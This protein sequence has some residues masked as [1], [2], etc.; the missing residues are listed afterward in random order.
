MK[1]LRFYLPLAIISGLL[2]FIA[3]KSIQGGDTSELVMAGFHRLVAH[4]PGYPLFV[5]LQFTWTHLFE[6]STVFWRAS[7]LSSLFGAIALAAVGL[8]LKNSKNL[9]W[10]LLLLVVGLKSEVLESSVLPDVF[11]LH[12]L[13][14]ALIGYFFLFSPHPKKHSWVIFL[15]ILSLTNHHTAVFLFPVFLYSFWNLLVRKEHRSLWLA[16]VSGLLLFAGLYFSILLLNPKHSLSWGE[17]YNLSGLVHHFLRTDYGTF[18]LAATQ[19]S[20][21]TEAFIFMLKNLWP[22][23]LILTVVAGLSI[24]TK[25]IILKNGPFI[26]WSLAL[27]IT[28]AFPLIMN[29]TS[30]HVGAEVLRRFHVMPIM[31]L[32]SW[33][34]FL[35]RNLDLTKKNRIIL[36]ASIMP[37]LYSNF[38]SAPEFFDLRNDSVI[39]DYAKN[40]YSIGKSQ[41]NSIIVA[42][43]DTS[44]FALRYLQS[45]DQDA[46]NAKV[47]I[48][49]LPLFFHQ[50]YLKKVQDQ[51][52]GFNL[53]RSEEIYLKKHINKDQDIFKPNLF[54]MRFFLTKGYTEG[55]MYKVTFFPLGRMLEEGK[56]VFFQ[57]FP[58]VIKTIPEISYRGPQAFTKLKLFFEYSHYDYARAVELTEANDFNGAQKSMEDAISKVPYAYPAMASLCMNF[59]DKYDF[60]KSTLLQKLEEQTLYFY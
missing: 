24:K 60:C 27:L 40:F 23:F 32:T 18:Q 54:Q 12:A 8:P 21:G 7:I 34:L 39:E 13:F 57:D 30:K 36:L 9:L 59:P 55:S 14:I 42:E 25:A 16:V 2:F 17:V 48:V 38:V 52:P 58:I 35:L 33:A 6:F 15:F 46:Q 37:A 50:W 53:P 45:F 28:L 19:S 41:K 56:G 5:W 44:Y 29:V 3:P 31:I 10:V 26:L 49:S 11:S 47:A 1:Q 4:P 20:Q 22:L 43:T 51:I